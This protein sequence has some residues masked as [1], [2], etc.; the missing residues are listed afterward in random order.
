MVSP[1]G[2]RLEA[3]PK[4]GCNWNDGTAELRPLSGDNDAT[5]CS[6]ASCDHSPSGPLR[7]CRAHPTFAFELGSPSCAVRFRRNVVEPYPAPPLRGGHAIPPL[8][9]GPV[10]APS[11]PDRIPIGPRTATRGRRTRRR[12]ALASVTAGPNLR[13]RAGPKPRSSRS[14]TEAPEAELKRYA[15]HPQR[16]A[17]VVA[18]AARRP[19]LER[20]RARA[21]QPALVDDVPPAPLA[22]PH[23]PSLPSMY[24]A[25]EWTGLRASLLGPPAA[26]GVRSPLWLSESGGA[27][28]PPSRP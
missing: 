2:T 11:S 15:E 14:H 10:A 17:G 28:A 22:I 18:R 3:E 8:R 4:T 12:G 23:L 19:A 9:T 7:S 24:G 6:Q 25:L 5:V 26:L 21:E 16:L 1:G 20:R 27:S 13:F